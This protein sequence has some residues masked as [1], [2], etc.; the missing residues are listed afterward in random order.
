LIK[1]QKR[2]NKKMTGLPLYDQ[3]K[4]TKYKYPGKLLLVKCGDFYECFDEDACILHEKINLP[5]TQ[6]KKY[7]APGSFFTGVAYQRLPFFLTLLEKEN[8][9]FIV[10]DFKTNTIE[11]G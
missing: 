6:P 4:E 3:Y 7:M 2:E 8:V 11:E 5:E 9:P 10:I 1:Y